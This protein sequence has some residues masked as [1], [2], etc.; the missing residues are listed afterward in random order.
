MIEYVKF[1]RMAMFPIREEILELR[2]I[3]ASQ[4]GVKGGDG[5]FK[6]RMESIG[7]S[8][9]PRIDRLPYQRPIT[10]KQFNSLLLSQRNYFHY[11]VYSAKGSA[12]K[13]GQIVGSLNTMYKNLILAQ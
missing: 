9:D 12:T 5:K 13:E 2:L 6:I 11:H 8:T 10:L 7:G 1:E 4:K 3:K